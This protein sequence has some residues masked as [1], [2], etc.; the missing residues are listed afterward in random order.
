MSKVSFTTRKVVSFIDV[1]RSIE[2]YDSGTV[3]D[4][5]ASSRHGNQTFS[6]DSYFVYVFPS[7]NGEELSELQQAIWDVCEDAIEEDSLLLE[8]CW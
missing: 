6:N 2:G 4:H 1:V 5:I 8:V 3:W 7:I